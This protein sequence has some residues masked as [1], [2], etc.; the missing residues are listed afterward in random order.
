MKILPRE[1]WE[2]STNVT[3]NRT[4]KEIEGLAVKRIKNIIKKKRGWGPRVKGIKITIK[5]R[6][7]RAKIKIRWDR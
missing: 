3:R 2:L 1:R 4:E 6:Q 5:N 7:T